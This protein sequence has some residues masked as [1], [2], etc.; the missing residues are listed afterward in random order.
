MGSRW[1]NRVERDEDH[2]P[3]LAA[4]LPFDEEEVRSLVTAL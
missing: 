4:V 3:L 1:F 2:G